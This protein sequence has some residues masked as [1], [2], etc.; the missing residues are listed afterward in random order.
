MDW[1]TRLR[2]MK[3]RQMELKTPSAPIASDGRTMK[4]KAYTDTTA[5]GLTNCI[6]AGINGS[7]GTA[8]RINCRG[9]VRKERG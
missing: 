3:Y 6:I 2:E 4:L 7:G 1:K 5:N 9:Q 8:D